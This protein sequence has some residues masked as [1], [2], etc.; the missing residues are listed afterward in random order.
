MQKDGTKVIF[1]LEGKINEGVFPGI[2]GG[3]HNHQIAGE[4]FCG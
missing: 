2:Q 4:A 3:P 1:D